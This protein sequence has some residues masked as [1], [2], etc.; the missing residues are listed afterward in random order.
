MRRVVIGCVAVLGLAAADAAAHGGSHP[1]P[2]PTG[3]PTPASPSGGTRAPRGGRTNAGHSTRWEE[4]WSVN[5]WSHLRIRRRSIQSTGKETD[6]PKF[7]DTPAGKF[8]LAALKDSHYDTRSAA[9]IALGKAGT[10]A[11][12]T[13]VRARAFD[14]HHEVRESA[15]L[16]LALLRADLR[17]ADVLKLL[18]DRKETPRLRA[19]AA[20][21]LGLSRDPASVTAL[22][23]R[24]RAP[25]EEEEVRGAAALGLGLLGETNVIIEL[26]RV[27]LNRGH[28]DVIRANAVTALAQLAKIRQTRPAVAVP[29]SPAK[30]GRP[31]PDSLVA[32]T[33]LLRTWLRTDTRKAVRRAALLGFGTLGDVSHLDE[34]LR[35]MKVD[36]DDMVQRLGM[37]TAA[38]LAKGTDQAPRVQRQLSLLCTGSGRMEGKGFAA[39]ALG[40]LGERDGGRALIQVFKSGRHQSLRGAGAIGLGLLRHEPAVE[41]LLSEATGRGNPTLRAQSTIALGMIGSRKVYEPLRT[42]LAETDRP[43][44]KAAAA[45]GLALTGMPQ[46]IKGVAALLQEKNAYVR[47]SAVQALGILRDDLA[48]EPLM[49]HF[50]SETGPEIKALTVVA[51]GNILARRPVTALQELARHVNYLLRMPSL[52]QAIRLQ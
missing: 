40:L 49:N 32:L 48:L 1:T 9:C 19:M 10:E 37:I 14:K 52:Q 38:Q 46:D 8:L 13:K 3:T 5:R 18:A 31:E 15:L 17:K 43:Q 45:A 11:E 41:L 51:V 2:F 30:K 12:I 50:K 16:G 21:A 42:M 44:I 29:G 33:H 39:I 36:N 34:V 20:L 25:N 23:D 26:Q 47:M 4:W 28:A 7:A 27:A 24:M 22:L 35:A 6:A